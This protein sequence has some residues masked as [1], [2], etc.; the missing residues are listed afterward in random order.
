M[1]KV[2]RV[3][4]NAEL[5]EAFAG[6]FLSPLYDNPQPTP[7]FHREC[8][9]MYC[10]DNELAA[11]AAPRSHAKS[12]ALTHDYVLAVTM[13]R[14]QDFVVIISATEDLAMS[15]L[16]DIAKELRENDDMIAQFK[17]KGFLVDI[18]TDIVVEFQ[19]G[20]QC[21]IIAKGSGQKMRGL[22]WNGKRPGLIVCDDLED[23]AQ[24]ENKESRD[25][26]QRWFLRAVLP[27][28]RRGGMVRVHGTILHEDS[29]LAKLMKAKTWTT[30]LYKAHAGF[31]DFEDILWPEQFP[32]ERLRSIRQDYIE[33]GDAGGYSQ[34]Y[35][36]DPL[37][38]S[39]AYLRSDD[40]IAMD[41]DDRARD[42]I[43]A[44][45]CDF[46]V[47]KKD[48]ANKTS[49][50]IGGKCSENFIHVVDQ[51]T[52][53]WD[54]LEWINEMFAIQKR[55]NPA[56]FFV[57]DGVIWKS[58]SPTL[59]REMQVRDRW[60]NCQP[61]LPTRDK[62]TRGRPLQKHMRAGGM[63]FDKEGSWYPAYENELLRFT[64][65]NESAADDQFDSTALLV[66]GFETMAELEEEDF[67]D[68]EQEWLQNN[69]PRNTMG[70]SNVTGY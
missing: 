62:A 29:L 23:D 44:V 41:D 9:T 3:K 64:G 10:A 48:K 25:R 59:Y 56:V 32:E 53:R 39:E 30:R 12:T 67:L 20:H 22:K 51:R 38:N 6:T 65:Y 14:E 55:W 31:D 11:V 63:K 61:V 43:Y 35:L 8:W 52:G 33:Q 60:I 13:F 36:N 66:K 21:R 28:R 37:D 34:E 16:A 45:G 19:D 68:E 40:F 24:I 2:Q 26:F 42:K 57:E 69:D 46:A 54:T 27:T 58:V 15:H 7:D 5:I 50:T 70:R 47:S 1:S 4:L 49:F 17:I 18:K